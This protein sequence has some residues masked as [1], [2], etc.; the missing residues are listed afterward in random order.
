[1][2]ALIDGHVYAFNSWPDDGEDLAYDAQARTLRNL[3]FPD[4]RSDYLIGADGTLRDQRGHRCGT[5]A[6]LEP[7]P[8]P[9]R[10]HTGCPPRPSTNRST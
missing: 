9:K 10:R 2:P 5:V 8:T 1:M 3:A 4:G 6:D 7:R